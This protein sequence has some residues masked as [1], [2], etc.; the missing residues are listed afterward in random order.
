MFLYKVRPRRYIKHVFL[1]LIEL[2]SAG[3]SLNQPKSKPYLAAQQFA[4]RR[5]RRR[6]VPHLRPSLRR[7][8]RRFDL[9]RGRRRVA[10]GEPHH[11]E[12]ILGEIF[13][14]QIEPVEELIWSRD[15][16]AP[17]L[18]GMEYVQQLPGTC[19]QQLRLRTWRRICLQAS[20]CGI[21][22]TRVSAMHPAKTETIA[23]VSGAR[24]SATARTCSSVRIAVTFSSTPAAVSSFSSGPVDSRIVLVTGIF[25]FVFVPTSR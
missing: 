6:L 14:D 12:G 16:I 18:L 15:D 23:G 20:M 5:R 25:T 8:A 17:A 1:V 3:G 24:A 9:I 4:S 11:L 2:V 10:I 7:E 21:G 22:S 19:P 13:V